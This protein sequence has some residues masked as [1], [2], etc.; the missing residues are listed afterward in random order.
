[1]VNANS[2]SIPNNILMEL[3]LANL[4]DYFLIH[5]VGKGSKKNPVFRQGFFLMGLFIRVGYHQLF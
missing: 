1:M 2:K 5:L 4:F 3:F